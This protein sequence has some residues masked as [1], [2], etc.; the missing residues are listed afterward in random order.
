MIAEKNDI[1]VSPIFNWGKEFTLSSVNGEDEL[2]V[3]LRLVGDADFNRARIYALRKSAE[4]RKRLRTEDSD[5]KLAFLLER[6]ELERERL[7]S[8]CVLFASK[9]LAKEAIKEVQVPLPKEPKSDAKTEVFEKYQQAIDDYPKKR[10]DALR[11]YISREVDRLTEELQ[12]KTDDQL[13]DLYIA[14]VTDELC[15]EEMLTAFKEMCTYFGTYKDP[16]FKERF[17]NSFEDFA[18]LDGYLKQQ[19]MS[20]YA[21]LEITTDDLKKLQQVTP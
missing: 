2:K 9:D 21:S 15:E 19:F 8:I 6:G 17:F 14:Y 10:E 13:Y 16:Q 3:F 12:K 5:D 4:K 20:S 11:K 18:N 1:D 7:I